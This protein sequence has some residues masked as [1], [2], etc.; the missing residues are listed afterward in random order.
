ML[1]DLGKYTTFMRFI[2]VGEISEHKQ[3][4][5]ILYLDHDIGCYQ[6][7]STEHGS[8]VVIYTRRTLF[9]G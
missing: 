1:S 9:V 2:V 4:I 7:V 8:K 6:Q 3:T 5:S